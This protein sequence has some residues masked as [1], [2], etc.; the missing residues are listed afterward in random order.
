MISGFVFGPNSLYLAVFLKNFICAAV[1]LGLP[2]SFS[3][4]VSLPHSRVGTA[5]VLR[6]RNLV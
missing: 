1:I 4:H 2:C 6:I 3:V 5:R